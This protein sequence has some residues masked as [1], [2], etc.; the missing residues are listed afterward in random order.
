MDKLNG[1]GRI[2]VHMLTDW[3]PTYSYDNRTENVRSLRNEYKL[4]K[5][6]RVR[7]K[8]RSAE[9]AA[10]RKDGEHSNYVDS[11]QNTKIT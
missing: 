1:S 3:L 5:F 4:D 2:P 10:F 6:T 8:S 9:P 7:H 11:C